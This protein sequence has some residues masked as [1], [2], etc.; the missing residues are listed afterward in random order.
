MVSLTKLYRNSLHVFTVSGEAAD[1]LFPLA[2][3]S[4]STPCPAALFRDNQHW[5]NY[6]FR[7]LPTSRPA[8]VTFAA[9]KRNA[10]V[11]S[12]RT[13]RGL[14]SQG[15]STSGLRIQSA[16]PPGLLLSQASKRPT[17][18]PTDRPTHRPSNQPA[19]QPAA[20]VP[21]TLRNSRGR[22]ATQALVDLA[23]FPAR[24]GPS[25]DTPPDIFGSGLFVHPSVCLRSSM[26]T[27][28]GDLPTH[29]NFCAPSGTEP[30]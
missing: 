19:S 11:Y 4:A 8:S 5:P 28:Q 7:A 27:Q 20:C 24:G 14:R 18:G 25:K 13:G 26:R 3:L 21:Y 30:R 17:D 2:S 12:L 10:R 9:A 1:L 6:S 15:P 23:S 16:R 29:R 22:E